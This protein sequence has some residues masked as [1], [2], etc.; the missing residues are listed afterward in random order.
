MAEHWV[1]HKSRFRIASM[2]ADNNNLMVIKFGV[3]VSE[4]IPN[5]LDIY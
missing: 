3:G 5:V 4:T 2:I 1:K